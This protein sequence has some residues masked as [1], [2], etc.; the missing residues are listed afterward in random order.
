LLWFSQSSQNSSTLP[1]RG[2]DSFWLSRHYVICFQPV[3]LAA[4]PT[5]HHPD[6]FSP[7]TFSYSSSTTPG[8][9]LSFLHCSACCSICYSN[10]L[11]TSSSKCVRPNWPNMTSYAENCFST[12][13]TRITSLAAKVK[14][15]GAQSMDS[16][17]RE[18][19]SESWLQG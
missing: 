11:H 13:T 9:K 12:F 17:A 5:I 14:V 6:P 4:P 8:V 16:G 18:T 2:P 15:A 19:G 10:P 7:A 1:S 3:P